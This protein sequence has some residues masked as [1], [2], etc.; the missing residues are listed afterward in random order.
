MEHIK[1]YNNVNEFNDDKINLKKINNYLAYVVENNSSYFNNNNNYFLLTYDNLSYGAETILLSNQSYFTSLVDECI[2]LATNTQITTYKYKFNDN[3]TENYVL[4]RWKPNIT[5]FNNAF[6]GCTTLKSI[7][8]DL[9]SK[10]TEVT[11][12]SNTF[13]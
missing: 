5:N 6:S 1:L 4:I 12:F 10:Y 2:D 9:F 3:S 11:D 8:S 13:T 7:P